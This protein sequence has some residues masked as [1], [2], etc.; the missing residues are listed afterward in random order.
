[1]NMPLN[2]S[3]Q[4][5][6][7]LRIPLLGKLFP[8]VRAGFEVV[9]PPKHRVLNPHGPAPATYRLFLRILRI[10]FLWAK[11]LVNSNSPKVVQ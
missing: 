8:N 5:P 6:A 7:E 11:A 2:Y 3:P 1:M 4:N 10:Q 9:F